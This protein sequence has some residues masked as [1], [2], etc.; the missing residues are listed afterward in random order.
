VTTTSLHN[1]VRSSSFATTRVRLWGVNC[2]E[3]AHLSNADQPWAKQAA[4]FTRSMI[5]QRTVTLWLE[6]HQSRDA[7]S[8]VLAHV[9]LSD[10]TSLNA[11]LLEAGLARADD[12]VPHSTLMRYAQLELAARRG[13]VGIWSESD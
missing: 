13:A 5:A 9:E 2:P 6:S 11:A 7:F 3:L 1:A 8:A 4:E 10:G 12:R